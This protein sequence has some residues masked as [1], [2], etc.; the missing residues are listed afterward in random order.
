MKIAV[1][2][3][4]FAH[5]RKSIIELLNKDKVNEYYFISGTETN[6]SYSSLKLYD[7]KDNPK[8]IKVRNYWFFKSFLWQKELFTSIK[9]GHYE[10]V[11]LFA[12]WKYISTWLVIPYLILN[13]T[14]FLFWSHGLLN[15]KK[16]LNNALK[17]LFFSFFKNGGFVYDN[18]AKIIM[19]SKGYKN[20][21]DVIFNSLDYEKQ[22]KA[23]EAIANDSG[24]INQDI[25]KPYVIFSGRIIAERKLELLFDAIK[26]LHNNGVIINVLIIGDGPHYSILKE[27]GEK[28]S[29]LEQVKFYG[30]CYDEERLAKFFVD[31]IACVFPGPVG[32]TAIHA[33]TY[34]TP[35]ITNDNIFSQKPEIEAVKEGCTG[36]FYKEGDAASLAEKIQYFYNLSFEE[37]KEFSRNCKAEIARNFTAENQREIINSRISSLVIKTI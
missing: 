9:R 17:M 1:V 37:R 32:L 26:I 7:F 22:L 21:I 12:D 23:L 10:L 4:F 3:P 33:L 25:N 27:Y 19:E 15:K 29:I 16:S 5:Y 2:Y 20:N 28:L 6:S 30:S 13:R 24:K 34:G 18:R 35:V 14:P 31:S 8:F 11:I 36:A